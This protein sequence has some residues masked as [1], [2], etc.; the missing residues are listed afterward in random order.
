M[1]TFKHLYEKISKELVLVA[2]R[3]A[4]KGGKKKKRKDTR[5]ALKDTDKYADFILF[6]LPHFKNSR[7]KPKEIYDGISRKKRTIIVPSFREQVV[8][9]LIVDLLKPFFL[10]GIYEHAYGS[11]P[12]RGVHDAKRAIEKWIRT[13]SENCKYVLKMDI[14]KYFESIP[15]DILKAKLA[16]KIIDKEMIRI[17]F[18][19]IDAND[20]GLPLGFYTSQWLSMWYLKDFDHYIKEQC[21][22]IHYVRYMD[23]LVIFDK[24]KENLHVILNHAINYLD[25]L[26]LELNNKTQIFPLESRDLDFM[27]FRFFRNKTTLRRGIFFKMLRKSRKLRYRKA[28]IY[29]VRQMLSYLGWIKSTNIYRIYEQYI[30]PFIDF[31]SFKKRIS[32]YDRRVKDVVLL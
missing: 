31:K 14:R 10:Q 16:E 19:V 29:E 20:K 9:H 1:K 24:S 17:L 13:D 8:H 22:A 30:K 25:C 12:N 6:D 28:T 15:H 27:G 5:K 3:E 4:S 7:H 2:I 11:I 18:E 23:D 26:G 32:T 21:H